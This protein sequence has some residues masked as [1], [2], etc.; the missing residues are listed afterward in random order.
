MKK[1]SIMLLSSIFVV[2]IISTLSGCSKIAE[3]QTDKSN[4]LVNEG[5]WKG[6]DESW[7]GQ[8]MLDGEL[9]FYTPYEVPVEIEKKDI[10]GEVKSLVGNYQVPSKN[11]QAN[12]DIKGSK[13]ARYE[14]SMAVLIDKEWLLFM[15]EEN[16][17]KG[18]SISY[19]GFLDESLGEE[20]ALKLLRRIA[21]GLQMDDD[22]ENNLD[23]IIEEAFRY[24]GIDDPALLEEAKSKI[25]VNV[26]D[27]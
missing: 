17:S 7:N 25:T 5:K 24:C 13:Y 6:I 22:Y 8:V 18:T 26:S 15:N 2:I 1:I 14:E 11:E 19:S 4:G 27:E 9:Y 10:I 21:F 23:K 12:F 3:N 16:W 20:E